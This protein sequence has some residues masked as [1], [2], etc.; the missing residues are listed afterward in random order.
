MEHVVAT[1]LSV[2]E[3][4]RGFCPHRNTQDILLQMEYHILDTY[5]Q[6]RL[7]LT[8]YVNLEGA[9]DVALYDNILYKLA[10]CNITHTS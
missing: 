8:L 5:R 1:C 7:M 4:Q 3:A 9:F 6:K 10:N 2:N